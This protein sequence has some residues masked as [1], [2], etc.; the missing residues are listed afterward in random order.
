MSVELN[1]ENPESIKFGLLNLKKLNDKAV[2]EAEKHFNWLCPYCGNDLYAGNDREAP[3][4]DHFIPIKK[5]GQHFP[6][7]LLRICF[8]CN[9]RK[10]DKMPFDFIKDKDRYKECKDY[11]NT[12]LL[13][14]TNQHNDFLQIASQV[15]I[16][17]KQHDAN[18]ISDDELI[19]D[20]YQILGIERLKQEEKTLKQP[21]IA[22]DE[23]IVH[24]HIQ[25]FWNALNI[26]SRPKGYSKVKFHVRDGDSHRIY[27]SLNKS[28]PIYRDYCN[29]NGIHPEPINSLRRLFTRTSYEPFIQG[30]QKG[31]KLSI[32]KA[33]LGGC[34]CFRYEK[35]SINDNM[36]IIGGMQITL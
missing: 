13:K 18:K 1:I 35:S 29:L 4:I 36:I 31:R 32:I 5:G 10:T 3:E 33:G 24:E 21:Q 34:Y 12:V 8:E 16:L 11:L 15:E 17:V 2:R 22:S 6:W 14:C 30:E 25:H 20:L 28:Y 19:N 23:T 27:I 7:N 9:R 26:E